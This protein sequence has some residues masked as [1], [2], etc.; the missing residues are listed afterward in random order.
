LAD[1]IENI[2]KEARRQESS[3][4]ST[5]GMLLDGTD[6]NIAPLRRALAVWGLTIDDIGVSSVSVLPMFEQKQCRRRLLF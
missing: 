4:L 5:Y 1:R 6:P 2:E 3:A